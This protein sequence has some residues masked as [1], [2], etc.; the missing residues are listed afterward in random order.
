MKG[1]MMSVDV[2]DLTSGPSTRPGDPRPSLL[3]VIK[4]LELAVR[5]HLDDIV[6]SA[7]ITALQYTALTVLDHHDGLSLAQLARDSFVTPQSVSDLVANLERNDLVRRDRNPRN[8]RELI[9]SLTPQGRKLLTTHAQAVAALEAQLT[10]GL[11]H[12]QVGEF[13]AQLD[14]CRRALAC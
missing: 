6:R 14:S 13:R 7:G 1:T 10:S 2:A 12:T 3:D 9:V 8:R 4:Q 11:T 5:S